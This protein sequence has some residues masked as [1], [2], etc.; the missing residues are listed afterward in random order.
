MGN[1][2]FRF[3]V[4]LLGLVIPCAGQASNM[5]VFFMEGATPSRVLYAAEFLS[6]RDR[7]PLSAITD[8]KTPADL[9]RLRVERKQVLMRVISVHE[10]ESEPE[11]VDMSVEFHCAP[12]LYRVSAAHALY[13]D[14]SVKHPVQM[15]WKPLDAGASPWPILAAS[16]ACNNEAVYEA[17]TKMTNSPGKR[18]E[19][20]LRTLGLSFAGDV[21]RTE[22]VDKV[23]SGLWANQKRPA[24][25]TKPLTAEDKERIAKTIRE[26][27]AF[28]SDK[29]PLSQSAATAKADL[30]ALEAEQAFQ[31]DVA[32]RPKMAAKKSHKQLGW[33]IGRTE[34]EVVR[35]SGAPARV[36]D[37]G[38]ARFL[39]YSN[40]Y[41]IAGVGFT[42]GPNGQ[43]APVSGTLVTCDLS[44]EMRRG[45][46]QPNTY[47]V[48]DYR[49]DATNGGC[50]DLHW[51]NTGGTGSIVPPG[52][53]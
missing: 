5:A 17:A 51:F 19:S 2:C 24:Y 26:A 13:R 42:V 29:G 46:T 3:F 25:V 45:G 31:N 32:K 23:W 12:K 34:T 22:L 14:I 28:I 33:L 11:S 37:A 30:S 50:R 16:I 8:A 53:K 44:I 27:E 52:S 10:A 39:I 6:V 9:E 40:E 18:D 1:F 49:L 4:T 21:G 20:A 41:S 38:E 43:P 7:T 36:T 35:A 15:E 47:R 48:V